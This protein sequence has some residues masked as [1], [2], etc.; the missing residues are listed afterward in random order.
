MKTI[1][2]LAALFFLAS[3]SKIDVNPDLDLGLGAT[4]WCRANNQSVNPVRSDS[5]GIG[6]QE[7]PEPAVSM[8]R[9][10]K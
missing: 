3:C 8:H 1:I 7:L 5:T 10:N 9:K 4:G 6:L 2:F